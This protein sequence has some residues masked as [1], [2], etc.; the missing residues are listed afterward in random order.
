MSKE[1]IVV[2]DS[3]IEVKKASWHKR[4]WQWWLSLFVEEYELT[5]WFHT[6]TVE[7]AD[8]LKTIRRS[9]KVFILKDISKKTSTHITGKDIFGKPFEIKTVE[10][11]DFQL[12][13]LK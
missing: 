13:K 6:E 11:F 2:E 9:S 7:H 12:R 10:P 5:V 8:G 3:K 4:L 1:N